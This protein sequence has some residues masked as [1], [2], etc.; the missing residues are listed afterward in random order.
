MLDHIGKAD[1]KAGLFEPWGEDFKHFAALPN[2]WCKLSGI[3]TEADHDNW[4][5]DDIAPF[6]RHAV[7][8]FGP[9]RLLY[10]GDWPVVNL[11]GDYKSWWQ[12]IDAALGEL[13]SPAERKAV[14]HD[15]AV[16]FYRLP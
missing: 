13:L 1:I 15:N 9:Q 12:A 2:T 8:C 10:G 7:E 16:A 3:V 6:I 14:L 4:T 11:A 5:P